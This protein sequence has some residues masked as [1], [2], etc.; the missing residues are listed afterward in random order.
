MLAAGAPA[1]GVVVAVLAVVL[2][3]VLTLTGELGS[4]LRGG[5]QVEALLATV[6]SARLGSL[7]LAE[8]QQAVGPCLPGDASGFE[9]D[10]SGGGDVLKAKLEPD[11]KP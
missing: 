8:V 5:A 7:Q 6:G 4:S 9:P 10:M 3:A 2:V 1:A 11:P